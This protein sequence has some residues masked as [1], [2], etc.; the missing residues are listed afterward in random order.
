[1]L[2]SVIA[3]KPAA[4][5][6]IVRPHLEYCTSAWSPHY[7]KDKQLLE[8]IQHRFTRMLPGMKELPYSQRLRKVGLW[9]V[10]AR[11][12]RSD[13]IEVYKMLHGKPA[14][15]FDSLFEL[16]K[17]GR[18]RG[19]SLKLKK[20]RINTDLRQH[21]FFSERIVDIWNALEDKLVCSSSLNVFKYGL[22]QLW[23]NDSS[24][25]GLLYIVS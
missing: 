16:D 23:K 22:H 14:D 15:N 8:R 17:F 19:H 1:M 7:N 12:Y 9:S 13:I 18:T 25:M 20:R 24:P 21:K 3:I 6:V 4:L 11:R 5:G 10:E 2:L